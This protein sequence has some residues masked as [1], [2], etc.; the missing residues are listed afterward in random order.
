[1]GVLTE[2]IKMAEFIRA[3]R[4]EHR[5]KLNVDYSYTIKYEELRI[6]CAEVFKEAITEYADRFGIKIVSFHTY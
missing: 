4:E 5:L 3:M 6:L 2:G 1:M